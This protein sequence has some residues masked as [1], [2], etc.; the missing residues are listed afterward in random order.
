MLYIAP[1][2]P[3]DRQLRDKPIWF[4]RKQWI[5]ANQ[6]GGGKRIPFTAYE[7]WMFPTSKQTREV[8][9]VGKVKDCVVQLARTL[10]KKILMSIQVVEIPDSYAPWLVLLNA[11]HATRRNKRCVLIQQHQPW[12]YWW[13]KERGSYSFL[14]SFTSSSSCLSWKL[15][16]LLLTSLE[17][18]IHSLKP[19]AGNS[20]IVPTPKALITSYSCIIWSSIP[21]VWTQ[22]WNQI[23]RKK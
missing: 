21:F 6:C 18:S 16:K 9:V 8:K 10:E 20:I 3:L 15:M 23:G 13:V 4:E 22:E 17:P 11:T 5:T 7:T 1:P 2:L 12:L 14:R 19:Q